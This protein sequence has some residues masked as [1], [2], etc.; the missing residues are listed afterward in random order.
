MPLQNIK[1]YIEVQQIDPISTFLETDSER[2][3]RAY[4]F[5]GE[6]GRTAT[7]II[8]GIAALRSP[9]A[10]RII[11][12]PRGVGRSHLMAYV[13]ALATVPKARL[14]AQSGQGNAQIANAVRRLDSVSYLPVH[15][16]SAHHRAGGANFGD[17]LRDGL[18][19]IP[20]ASLEFDDAQWSLA[21]Q[22][23]NVCEL[24]CSKL[25]SGTALL[26]CIDDL[27]ETFRLARREAIRETLDWL[28]LLAAKSRELPIAVLVVLD[29]D[30]LD[31]QSG[32]A[33]RLA[34]EYQIDSL[35][36]DNLRRI[37]DQALFRKTPMQ[38]AELSN[39]Y[40]DIRKV[41]PRFHWSEDEF[42]ELYPLHPSA[43]DVSPG[44]SAYCENFSLF[45]FINAAVG[46]ALSR[47]PLQMILL[48]ELFD[49]FQFD[50]R[51]HQGLAPAL[52]VYDFLATMV[53]PLL[54][55]G[56]RLQAKLLLKGLFLYSLVNRPVS[57]YDLTNALMLY[58]ERNP[59]QGYVQVASLVQRLATQAEG[60]IVTYGE[61]A[62]PRYLITIVRRQDPD[63]KLKAAAAE[64]PDDERLDALLVTLG[65]TAFSDWPFAVDALLF[66][67]IQLQRYEMTLPWRN[68]LRRGVITYQAPIE[69]APIPPVHIERFGASLTPLALSAAASLADE[70]RPSVLYH[71]TDEFCEI[72]WEVVVLPVRGA[73]IPTDAPQLPT[74]LFWQ[75]GLATDADLDVLKQMWA[76]Y[77]HGEQVFGIDAADHFSQLESQVRELFRHLYLKEGFFISAT[78]ERT[79]VKRF[80]NEQTLS[81]T[82]AQAIHKPLD[83]RFPAHPVFKAPLIEREIKRLV[84]GLLGG[85]NPTDPAV[86]EHAANFAAPLQIVVERDGIFQLAM[87]RDE[88]LSQPVISETLRLVESSA[89][90][91]VPVQ[92]VYQILRREPFGLLEPAQQLVI[93]S[94][95]AGWRIELLDVSGLRAF[96]AVELTQD[97]SFRQ[98]GAIRRTTTITY[99]SD[100]LSEWCRLLT[101]RPD[102]PD[103][104]AAHARRQIRESLAIWHRT[105]QEHNLTA[106]FNELPMEMLTT[107]TWQLIITC[108]RYFE[109]TASAIEAVLFERISL[110]MGLARVI[111]IFSANQTTYQRA[112]IDLKLL[113]E[114]LDWLPFYVKAK[115]YALATPQIPRAE[116]LRERNELIDFFEHPHQLLDEAKRNN[117]EQTFRSFQKA[118]I[119]FY[120]ARHAEAMKTVEAVQTALVA[121]LAGNDW[122]NF[123]ILSSL[124][125]SSR[126]HLTLANALIAKLRALRCAMPTAEILK[127]HPVCA[128]NFRTEDASP[129]E[130]LF[131]ELS[132]VVRQGIEYHRRLLAANRALVVHH[133]PALELDPERARLVA[134]TLDALTGWSENVVVSST[135]PELINQLFEKTRPANPVS[136]PTP[137]FV[138]EALSKQELIDR[139]AAWA[140]TLPDDANVVFEPVNA[141]PYVAEV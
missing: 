5:S 128:C 18:R 29:E 75:P 1:S 62:E 79:P 52:E 111:D 108:K 80:L 88:A 96:G 39:L 141:V 121:L 109:T 73:T 15:I 133:L 53:I 11:A 20:D 19:A 119:D 42:S 114:F 94:L 140:D 66:G 122:R 27:S 61:G 102:L 107:R 139:F 83:I 69:I 136:S 100:V 4:H 86:Q 25:F 60:Q 81:D 93:M 35:T 123:E 34:T 49:Q 65:G 76:A 28:S 72:D 104:T 77:F 82:L 84:L 26:V 127:I 46:R 99:A 17:L 97:A 74:L 55:I 101:E 41:L 137:F 131:A 38:R 129:A 85:L 8:E 116:I 12:G 33:A 54:P 6:L 63:A 87:D 45:G 71:W 7:R 110:E 57:A 67:G 70:G 37:V 90:D 56:E 112:M 125:L 48:D 115:S 16:S 98:Y 117:F 89:N 30:V 59:E 120:L 47:R 22:Q 43:L 21:L 10:L 2:I 14:A 23:G 138:G 135:F 3:V 130:T 24:A 58:D 95:V 103:L 40:Q 68:A 44:M 106:R 113:V 92:A 126:R 31:P 134:D 124:S 50:L 64:V 105:W 91:P 78:G 32:P 118:Y 9:S 132:E 13:K 36:L 51:K